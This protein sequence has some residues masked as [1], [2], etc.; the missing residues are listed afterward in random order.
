M[1]HCL[2]AKPEARKSIVL[3]WLILFVAFSSLLCL[4]GIAE[5][6]NALAEDFE[7]LGEQLGENTELITAGSWTDSAFGKN[8]ILVKEEGKGYVLGGSGGNDHHTYWVPAVESLTGMISSDAFLLEADCYGVLRM[9]LGDCKKWKVRGAVGLICGANTSSL[10]IGETTKRDGLEQTASGEWKRMG[11]FCRRKE[12]DSG[13]LIITV[14]QTMADGTRH[15]IAGLENVEINL[16]EVPLAQWNGLDVRLDGRAKIDNITL[17]AVSE[18]EK[19]LAVATSTDVKPDFT[20]ILDEVIAPRSAEDLSGV[21]EYTRTESLTEFP[22]Q[23]ASWNPVLVPAQH[24]ELFRGYN[25]KIWFRRTFKS[26]ALAESM[27]AVLKFEGITD[28]CDV[29]INGKHV[30]THSL[31]WAPFEADITGALCTSGENELLIGVLSPKLSAPWTDRPV[32]WSWYA[33]SFSGITYPIHLLLRPDVYIADVF[34]KPSIK[35][36]GQLITEV[37]VCNLTAYNATVSVS[38]KVENEFSHT[39]QKI[40]IPAK[41]TVTVSL[42]DNWKNPPLWWPHDP[43]LRYLTTSLTEGTARIDSFNTRFGFREMEVKGIDLM[44]NGHRFLHRRDSII[45]YWPRM[46]E[47]SL[48]E[49][50]NLLRVRG[51]NGARLHGGG[52]IRVTRVADEMGMLLGMESSINE[53][54]GHQVSEAFW[55]RAEDH[56]DKIVRLYRNSPSVVYWCVSN[57]FGSAYMSRDCPEELKRR[58]DGWLDRMG[59]HIQTIDPTRSVTFCGD[60]ELGGIGQHGPSPNLSLHYPWQPYK[61]NCQVPRT[62][63]WLEQGE[64]P[65]QGVVWDQTKPVF[66]NECLY[67]DYEWNP[68]H[69]LAQW[70]GDSVYEDEGYLRAWFTVLRM[71]ADGYYHSGVACINP[72]GTQAG[73]PDSPLFRYGQ[74][75]PDFLIA[76]YEFDEGFWS[77]E[78]VTR[79]L[80]V[81]NQ[82]FRDLPCR[83]TME[84]TTDSVDVTTV[85]SGEENF[86]LRGGDRKEL[87]LTFTMPEVQQRTPIT[88]KL[89]VVS[90]DTVLT[91]REYQ[92]VVYPTSNP[93][94]APTGCALV[95]EDDTVLENTAFSAGRFKTVQEALAASPSCIVLV[96]ATLST[97]DEV[98]MSTAVQ[99]GLKVLLIETQPESKLPAPL[100]MMGG[101]FGFYAYIRSSHD[102][103]LADISNADLRLWGTDLESTR[104]ILLKPEDGVGDILLDTATGSGLVGTPLLRI[105]RGKGDYTF[106]QLPLISK[107]TNPA[108]HYVLSKLVSGFESSMRKR[109]GRVIT[110]A[111]SG[112]DTGIL[113]SLKIPCTATG[114]DSSQLIMID[115][116]AEYTAAE[117]KQWVNEAKRGM[118]IFVQDASD[119]TLQFLGREMGGV[120]TR[121]GVSVRKAC[122]MAD[123]SLLDGLSNADFYWV[124]NKKKSGKETVPE[125]DDALATS[126]LSFSS[127]LSVKVLLKPAVLSEISVGAGKIILCQI[128]WSKSSAAFPSQSRRV[129]ATMLKNCGVAAGEFIPAKR[130]YSFIP[131]ASVAN[132]GFHDQPENPNMARGWFCGGDDDMRYFPVNLT[133]LDPFND[134]PQPKEEFPQGPLYCTGIP[135]ALVNPENNAGKSCLVLSGKD[136]TGSAPSSIEITAEVKA[137]GIWFLGALEKM[138]PRQSG[139]M[140]VTWTYENGIRRTSQIKA[141]IDV[142]GYQYSMQIDKGMVGWR[143]N[144]R[145]YI[146]AVLWTWYVENPQSAMTVKSIILAPETCGIAITGMTWQQDQ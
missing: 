119:K 143:G 54:R 6:T 135:F 11:L 73:K 9:T 41:N 77:G 30:L 81:Y 106:C 21:W 55:P 84:L 112:E 110:D 15:K 95:S 46:Q 137:S 34:I 42:Q 48:H 10:L 99:N 141:G 146:D 40:T 70:A 74:P 133:G 91:E 53:P 63:Y 3:L 101:Q 28:T 62:V 7:V 16:S 69:G 128:R 107:R 72:W 13:K 131:L 127:S 57:E 66:L 118:T 114:A 113:T 24:Q 17:Q 100:R 32:G 52:S 90:G 121:E 38:G 116:Q 144:T 31:D 49:Y 36:G 111:I 96:Q 93:I 130:N 23:N 27:R 139:A 145:K 56:L 136:S 25:G 108:A 98:A 115:G 79:T 102:P 12:D 82:T 20:A 37:T 33:D 35:D 140:T 67:A 87:P 85:C 126:A 22:A 44:L 45:S 103:L 4:S 94:G 117:I 26:P 2:L 89:C 109:T 104:D 123:S 88:W 19:F 18:P 134:M 61:Q 64:R 97:D 50:F 65:W 59:Q 5:E 125:A 83:L 129:I 80:F 76:S 39:P 14:I 120:I 105:R 124:N 47:K 1:S 60:I 142:Q 58:V 75:L 8:P 122:R 138:M 29:Y 92:Y 86:F 51:Y 132:R 71:F 78:D 43:Q 68:P